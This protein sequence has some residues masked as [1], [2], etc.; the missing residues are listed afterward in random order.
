VRILDAIRKKLPDV[1]SHAHLEMVTRDCVR[2]EQIGWRAQDEVH[3]EE[4]KCFY[5]SQ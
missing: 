1:V 2:S 4:A 3:T 5:L